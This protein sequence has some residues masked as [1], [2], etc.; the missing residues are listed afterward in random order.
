M[1]NFAVLRIFVELII[2]AVHTFRML[3][4]SWRSRETEHRRAVRSHGGPRAVHRVVYVG[5]NDMGFE[6][7]LLLL[8]ANFSFPSAVFFIIIRLFISMLVSCRNTHSGR[9]GVRVSAG[10]WGFFSSPKCPYRLCSLP[11]PPVQWLPGFFR[12]RGG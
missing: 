5:S 3:L 12:E 1:T 6:L 9:S 11:K 4:R 2:N 8:F 10:A 7:Y